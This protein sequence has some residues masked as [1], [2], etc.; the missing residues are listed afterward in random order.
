M[1]SGAEQPLVFALAE[2]RDL[3][4]DVALGL[5]LELSP[6]EDRSFSHGEHKVRPLINV[7][8]RRVVVVQTLCGDAAMSANDKLVRLLFFIATLKE[9]AAGEVTAVVPYMVYARKDRQ[10]K[11]RDPVTTRYVAQL[12]GVTGADRLVAVDVHNLAAFQNAFRIPTEHVEAAIPLADELGRQLGDRPVS[13]VS[14]DLGGAKRARR[15]AEILS[16]RVDADIE[17]AVMEK[18]RSRGDIS[19]RLQL[20]GEVEGCDA[21]IVDD[22]IDGGGTMLR[23]AAA[24]R[25]QGATRVFACATHGAFGPDAVRLFDNDMIDRVVVTDSILQDR[26]PPHASLVVVPIGGWLARALAAMLSGGSV[27][28]LLEIDD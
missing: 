23:A 21:V 20:L 27:A 26:L 13:V 16:R 5:G 28:E 17:G 11:R 19:G 2:S 12:F 6:H 22:L 7:R 3:G 10:T 4:S 15:F 24:A 9:A 25:E 14:P 18:Y 1:R 8:D